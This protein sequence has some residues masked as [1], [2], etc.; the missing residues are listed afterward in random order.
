M[1]GGA[2]IDSLVGVAEVVREL[3]DFRSLRETLDRICQRAAGLGGYDG[4]SLFMADEDAGGLVIRGSWR[5]SDEYIAH[6]NRAGLLALDDADRPTVPPTVQAYM[7]GSA[8]AIRDVRE[9][10]AFH[11]KAEAEL[12]GYRAL[13]CTPVI[14]RAQVIGVL[15]CYGNDAR[16]QTREAAELLEVVAR[17][18]GVAIETARVADLRRTAQNELLET[19]ARLDERNRQLAHLATLQARLAEDVALPG[20]IAVDRAARTLAEA[21]ARSV[22]VTNRA[23]AV[24]A[25]HGRADGRAALAAA[26]QDVIET[27]AQLAQVDVGEVSCIRVGP[28]D[29]IVGVLSLHPRLGGAAS[30]EMLAARHTAAMIAPAL[31]ESA[32]TRHV[33]RPLVESA[34]L[35]AL[36]HGLYGRLQ[37]TDAVKEAGERASGAVRLAALKCATY[38]SAYRL[39]RRF[40]PSEDEGLAGLAVLGSVVDGPDCLVLLDGAQPRDAF[41]HAISVFRERHVE[42]VAAGLSGPAELSTLARAYQEALTAASLQAHGCGGV[43]MFD[44]LGI[45]GE[46]VR[47]LSPDAIEAVLQDAFRRL[48]TLGFR[49]GPDASE[50]VEAEIRRRVSGEASPAASEDAELLFLVTLARTAAQANCDTHAGRMPNGA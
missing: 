6:I 36:A 19:T 14:V 25:Y 34:V 13:V 49:E 9:D 16:E 2:R 23:G 21:L 4:A 43:V 10:P 50:V 11:W 7:T 27:L 45:Y 18:A 47:R 42:V 26:G 35:L 17:L 41:R 30:S 24:V 22:V 28:A 44:D 37:V 3:D 29:G 32:E 20:E 39:S 5:V 12:G 40:V 38:E 15:N 33:V 31:R 46:L 1:I 8:V 48:E